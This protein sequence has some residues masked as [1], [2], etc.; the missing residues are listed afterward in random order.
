MR[1]LLPIGHRFLRCT[2]NYT[3]LVEE[4][5]LEMYYFEVAAHEVVK[6]YMS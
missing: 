1:C 2:S 4:L 5:K 6:L 3:L